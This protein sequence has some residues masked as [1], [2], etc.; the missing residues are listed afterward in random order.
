MDTTKNENRGQANED[1]KMD[2]ALLTRGRNI[3][4]SF[5]G[6]NARPTMALF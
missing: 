3:H 2:S 5:L 6:T 1:T 4:Y